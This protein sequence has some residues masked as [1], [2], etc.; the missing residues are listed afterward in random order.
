MEA[1][2][3]G[4]AAGNVFDLGAATSSQLF[5]S[6]GGVRKDTSACTRATSAQGMRP[7]VATYSQALSS[8]MTQGAPTVLIRL[9]MLQL[10]G[11][12]RLGGPV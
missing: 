3:R 5:N 8:P 12:C 10:S 6:A 7:A 11:S 9:L 2:I 4:I 1:A